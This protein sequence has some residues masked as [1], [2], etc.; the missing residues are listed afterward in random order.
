[1]FVYVGTGLS[2]PWRSVTFTGKSEAAR[3]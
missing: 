3:K 2:N 1:M